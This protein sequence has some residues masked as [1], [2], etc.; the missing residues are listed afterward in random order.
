MVAVVRRTEIGEHFRGE[1]VKLAFACIIK[2]FTATGRPPSKRRLAFRV[3]IVISLAR[4]K[5]R[6]GRRSAKKAFT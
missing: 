5:S 3:A 2:S 1:V 4:F 6:R